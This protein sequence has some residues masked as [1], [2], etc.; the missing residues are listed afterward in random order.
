MGTSSSSGSGRRSANAEN[1]DAE[2]DDDE[3]G[4]EVYTLLSIYKISL[5]QC[6]I[7][8]ILLVVCG[9]LPLATM[10]LHYCST[11]SCDPHHTHLNGL[12]PAQ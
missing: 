4:Y 6:C 8:H 11:W 10:L 7:F 1:E 2:Q 5:Q 9:K 12:T 3:N